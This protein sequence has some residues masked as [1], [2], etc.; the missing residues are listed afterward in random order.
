MSSK[1][2]DKFLDQ[3]IKILKSKASETEDVMGLLV[4]EPQTTD[5]E[6]NGGGDTYVYLAVGQSIVASNG[7]V[8][9]AY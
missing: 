6:W 2:F 8:A 9:T 3:Q 4:G 7:G 1:T 5:G